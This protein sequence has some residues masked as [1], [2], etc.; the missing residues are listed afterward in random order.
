MEGKGG[1][2]G[3]MVR[4]IVGEEVGEREWLEGLGGFMVTLLDMGCLNRCVPISL[5]RPLVSSSA[6]SGLAVP[7]QTASVSDILQFSR[8]FC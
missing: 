8:L 5:I 1:G 2:E 7:Q 6:T 3:D 4:E